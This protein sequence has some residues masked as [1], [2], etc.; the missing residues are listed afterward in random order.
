[1]LLR[2]NPYTLRIYRNAEANGTEGEKIQHELLKGTFFLSMYQLERK[3]K[4]VFTR[5][6]CVMHLNSH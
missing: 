5:G 1:M 6:L 3:E 4:L 2:F